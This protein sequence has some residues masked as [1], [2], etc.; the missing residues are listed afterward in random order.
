MVGNSRLLRIG[1]I[2]SGKM[3]QHHLKAIHASGLATVVGVADPAASAEELLPLLGNA[4][5]IV[6][7][8]AEEL[9]ARARP[10]VVHI[11]T[12]PASHFALASLAIEAGCHVYVEKPFTPTADEAS[13][14][15]ALAERRG[16]K[17]CAGHQVLFEA[18]ALGVS[19]QLWRIGRLVHIESYFS[20]RMVRRTITSVEQ[21]KDILPHAVY[22]VVDQL[23]RGTGVTDDP[24]AIAGM[25]LDASGEAYVLLRLAGVTATVMVTLNG[26]PVEQYQNLSGTNG[27]LR[28]DYIGGFLGQL[29]GPGTGPGVL[30]TPYRRALHTVTGTTGGVARLLRG[31]SYPGLRTLVRRFYESIR[32]NTLPP[33]SPRSIIDTVSLCEQVAR[34]L[35]SIDRD[36]EATAR[37]RL[38]D[39]ESNLPPVAAGV[40]LVLLTGGTGLL[41]KCIASEVRQAGF[42]V[43]VVARRLPPYSRRVPG[44]Q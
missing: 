16:V 23:R 42:P 2:G 11:V 44:V 28:A 14:L 35:E 31:G 5:A 15:L 33:L 22:P 26:R 27:S 17:V 29:I 19:E 9:L 37:E 18:P 38:N 39:A 13:R 41:G 20:F 4:D 36:H 6:V 40:P 24:I 34:A 10:D 30:L 32:D 7:S 8:S 43:R 25:S 12:P 21:V 3:G 1:L